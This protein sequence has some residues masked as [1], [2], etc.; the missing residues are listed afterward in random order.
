MQNTN[1]K[2]RYYYDKHAKLSDAKKDTVAVIGYGI[3]GRAH[4]LNLRDSGFRVVIGNL[5]DRYR[6]QAVRDGFKPV[7]IRDAASQASIIMLLIPD[8]PQGEVF[9]KEIAPVLRPNSMVVVA[10]GFSLYYKQLVPDASTDVCLLAPRM[11]GKPIREYYLDRWGVPAYTSVVHDATGRALKRVL[12]LAKG[13]GFTRPGVL[14]VP[15]WEETE[16]DLFFEQLFLP[17]LNR[18]IAVC[19]DTLV[20][21]GYR[22]ATSLMELYASGELGELLL[23][24]T[25]IGLYRVFERHA[26][27]TCQYGIFRNIENMVPEPQLKDNIRRVVGEIRDGTFAQALQ[28]ESRGGFKQLKAHL[29]RQEASTLTKAHDR[30]LR[31]GFRTRSQ[32]AATPAS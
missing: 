2:L 21:L 6:K 19:F 30:L 14:E 29:R 7:S 8:E 28:A 9:A 26:S 17:V 5:K 15:V 10:H 22:P 31:G 12:A 11:P 13:M 18:T 3:Q 27:P 20:E 23:I 32:R 24:A 1:Q 4:A 25:N 16:L